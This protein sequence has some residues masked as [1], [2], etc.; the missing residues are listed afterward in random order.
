M[1]AS[2]GEGSA[3]VGRSRPDGQV[4]HSDDRPSHEA[5]VSGSDPYLLRKSLIVPM[6]FFLFAM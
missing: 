4:V 3:F 5:I 6:N 2:H 1:Q